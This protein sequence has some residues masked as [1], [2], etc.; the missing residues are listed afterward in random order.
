MYSKSSLIAI[1]FGLCKFIQLHR[2][3]LDIINGSNFK[4]ANLVF[5]AKIVELKRLGKAKIEHKPPIV[6]EDLNKLY[7][8]VVFD[9]ESP[10]G[11]QNKVWF[12]VMFFFCRR[13]QENLRDLTRD[14]FAV[15]V[16]A[17]GRLYVFQ[18]KDE[19]TKNRRE[20]NEAEEG[21]YMFEKIGDL[22]SPLTSFEKYVSKFEKYVSKLNPQCDAFFQRPKKMAVDGFWNEN[23][24]IGKNTL[25]NKMKAI[26][27]LAD[28]SREYTNHS[29]RATSVT[30]LDECGFEA[31]HIMC[32]SGHR[33]EASI[34][35]YASKTKSGIKLAMS[36]GLSNALCEIPNLAD[37]DSGNSLNIEHYC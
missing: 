13:G 31:H 12:E 3:E 2:P 11:L 17:S 16:D 28:L 32:V 26:S 18:V 20:N 35:S 19:L 23:Q 29:I 15:Q 22:L 37:Q 30:I 4:D 14:S 34:R 24:C 27:K 5:K 21:G 36:A 1:R 7:H 6:S 33:S 9:T 10:I 25:G 8:S